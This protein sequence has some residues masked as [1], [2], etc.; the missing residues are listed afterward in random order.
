MLRFLEGLGA[1]IG[2]VLSRNR[3]QEVLANQSE[4]LRRS[5][6]HLS[7]FAAIASHDLQEPIRTVKVFAEL[8]ERRYKGS[9]DEKAEKMIGFMVDGATRMQKLVQDVLT[10]S[11]LNS[12][13]KALG[14]VD[15]NLVLQEAQESLAALIARSGAT[16]HSGPLPVV[17]GDSN[18]LG[19]LFRNLLSNGLKFQTQAQAPVV[20][21]SA[22][23]T[24]GGWL[25][26]VADNG[27]GID[28]QHH[29][30]IFEMFQRLHSSGT[31]SGTG[32]GLAL[33][34]RIVNRHGGR[35]WVESEL[36]KGATFC[37]ILPA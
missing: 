20:S 12:G 13:R 15:C 37:F 34:H 19:Q 9:L 2:I 18:Q 33:C 22:T 1:S 7:K 29:D 32:I 10:Y 5:N 36:G 31:Y 30:R 16:V 27:I 25:L 17:Q 24:D 26:R 3:E 6:E 23:P 35:I 4:E 21:V 8:L 11:E 28:P 14:P